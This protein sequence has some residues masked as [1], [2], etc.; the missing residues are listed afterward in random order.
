MLCYAR[1]FRCRSGGASAGP[2]AGKAFVF[3]YYIRVECSITIVGISIQGGYFDYV[4]FDSAVFRAAFAGC[5]QAGEC[6]GAVIIVTGAG[7]ARGRVFVT[8][9]VANGR[10][11]VAGYSTAG[12]IIE[13][14]A[15][16]H[17]VQVANSPAISTTDD[18]VELAFESH[19]WT[20]TAEVGTYYIPLIVFAY[21]SKQYTGGLSRI[22][23]CIAKARYT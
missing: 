9:E 2:A 11:D 21:I 20:S 14:G 19:L 4:S 10:Y 22:D 23:T 6:T 8:D 18:R 7:R 12:Q 5:N 13:V 3:V 1:C 15:V 17:T 16:R